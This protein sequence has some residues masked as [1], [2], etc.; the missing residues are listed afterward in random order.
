[1]KHTC[2]MIDSFMQE[3]SIYCS[4][5]PELCKKRL[6]RLIEGKV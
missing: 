1:M 4:F 5:E 3:I 2:R 6:P